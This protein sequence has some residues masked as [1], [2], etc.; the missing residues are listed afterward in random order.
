[1]AQIRAGKIPAR[2]AFAHLVQRSRIAREMG[3]LDVDLAVRRKQSTVASV[4]CRNNTIEHIK[5]G[6]YSIDDIFGPAYP[7]EI[8]R[9]ILRQQLRRVS[10]DRPQPRLSL[11]DAQT[12]HRKTLK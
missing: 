1:M 5:A 9:P 8:T 12:A 10:A 4:A 2:V 6:A 3:A 7:H 11:A